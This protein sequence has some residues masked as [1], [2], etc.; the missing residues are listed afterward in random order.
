MCVSSFVQMGFWD[1]PKTEVAVAPSSVSTACVLFVLGFVLSHPHSF[2]PLSHRS[3]PLIR[4]KNNALSGYDKACSSQP[5]PGNPVYEAI[6]CSAPVGF[7]Q[8]ARYGNT[9]FSPHTALIRRARLEDKTAPFVHL[10]LVT[11]EATSYY[12]PYRGRQPEWLTR[13]PPP[14][15]RRRQ[16]GE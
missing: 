8:L 15:E 7:S 2:L 3:E 12:L 6:V 1:F 11:R 4:V 5:N 9:C 13:T 16:W 10:C 14:R